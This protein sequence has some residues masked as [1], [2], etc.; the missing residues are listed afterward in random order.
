[1]DLGNSLTGRG[2]IRIRC[3]KVEISLQ[4]LLHEA[5]EARVTVQAPPR[6]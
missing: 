2:E 5:I 3:D 1:M 4:R 6:I